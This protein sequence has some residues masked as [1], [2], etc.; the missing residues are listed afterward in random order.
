MSLI[1]LYRA[2][3]SSWTPPSCRF[4]PTCS[5]YAYEAIDRYGALKGGWLG[6]RR[7]L[8]CHPWGGSGF[9]PVP[10]AREIGSLEGDVEQ[11]T[12]DR[13]S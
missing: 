11:N 2:T 8:G 7:I 12:T 3:I 9:D 1:R 5:A 10:P 6:F 4:E 13:G